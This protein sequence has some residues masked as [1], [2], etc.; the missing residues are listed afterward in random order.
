MKFY[1]ILKKE[2][3]MINMEWMVLKMEEEELLVVWA[4]FSQCLEWEELVK[5]DLKK[6]KKEKLF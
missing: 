3:C 6:L 5:E 1:Q 4:I 2:N